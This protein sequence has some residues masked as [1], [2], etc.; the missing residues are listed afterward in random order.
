VSALLLSRREAVVESDSIN[1][2]IVDDD[3]DYLEGIATR[4]E[5]RGFAVTAANSGEKA[6]EAARERLVDIALVDLNMPGL[7]GEATL[8]ALKREHEWME[9]VILTAHGSIDSALQC[10]R[11]GAYSFLEKTC[12]MD[13]LLAVLKEAYQKRVMNKGRLDE[14]RINE[15]LKLA[16]SGSSLEILHR[17]KELDRKSA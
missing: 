1:L 10:A 9:V 11:S 8:A 15:I 16:Q 7:D 2:L 5:A 13:R 3:R 12:D 4:L 6:V 17:L 14:E